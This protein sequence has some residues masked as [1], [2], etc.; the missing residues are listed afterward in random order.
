MFIFMGHIGLKC[1]VGAPL[2]NFGISNSNIIES[3]LKDICFSLW[4]RKNMRS[5]IIHS[6]NIWS[7]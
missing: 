4:W 3:E 5:I 6:L 1:F 7:H 2:S